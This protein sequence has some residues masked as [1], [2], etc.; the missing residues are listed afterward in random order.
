MM[1]RVRSSGARRDRSSM[2]MRPRLLVATIRMSRPANQIVRVLGPI[3]ALAVVWGC[4]ALAVGPAFTSWSNQRLMLQH[5]AVV[6]VAAIGATLIIILGGI[7]L[8]VGASI[9]LGTM[10]IAKLMVLGFPG[11]LAAIGGIAG[12]AACGTFIGAMVTGHIARAFAVIAAIGAAVLAWPLTKG[13]VI[14]DS[15]HQ[16]PFLISSVALCAGLLLVPLS[17]RIPLRIK[18]L[19]PFIVTL[20]LWGALRGL[21]KGIGGNQPIYPQ[22]YGGVERLMRTADSGVFSIL[23][24]GVWI[25]LIVAALAAAMLYFTPFGRTII[26]IGSNENAARVCGIDVE[27]TK[28]RVY[29]I[30]I[31]CAGFAAVLQFADLTVGDPTTAA[32]YELKVIAAVVIGGASLSGG[33]GSIFGTLLG[34]LLMTAVDNGCNKLRLDN[35]VQEIATGAII[36]VAVILDQLRQRRVA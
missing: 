36:V 29:A 23:P 18:P 21:A 15:T 34:A 12:A 20:G 24:P 4:F 26:A 3:L 11:W 6:G 22:A 35:W 13:L 31:A 17:N 27:R 25:M 2:G 30:G 28:W 5:T 10:V 9:A 1:C 8:S 7:D 16:V 33:R 19:S 14:G 32:G